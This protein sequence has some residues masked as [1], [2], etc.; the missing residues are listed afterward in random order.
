[1]TQ[2]LVKF[3]LFLLGGLSYC[4]T[5]NVVLASNGDIMMALRK[6]ES[7]FSDDG[8]IKDKRLQLPMISHPFFDRIASLTVAYFKNDHVTKVNLSEYAKYIDGRILNISCS[9]IHISEETKTSKSDDSKC[10][11]SVRFKNNLPKNG[12]W[13]A[14]IEQGECLYDQKIRFVHQHANPPTAVILFNQ[15]HE[16]DFL[17]IEPIKNESEYFWYL[18]GGV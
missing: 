14:L 15:H 2:S 12:Q 11:T 9:L 3:V 10:N 13:A 7:L 16:T 18:R 1:M 17:K 4:N 6:P 5:Y 8:A